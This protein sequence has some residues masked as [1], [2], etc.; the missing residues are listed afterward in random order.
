M[1]NGKG[2]VEKIGEFKSASGA[3]MYNLQISGDRFGFGSNKPPCSEGDTIEFEY[4]QKGQY[5][6]GNSK[7]VVVVAKS[8]AGAS[9]S[10]GG[11]RSYGKDPATQTTIS[12]QSALNSALA[13]VNTLVLADAVPG[14]T[15]TAKAEDKYGILESLVVEKT[16]EYYAQST[17][18]E[19]PEE[20]V[21]SKPV[22]DKVASAKKDWT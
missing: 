17:G 7:S 1:S 22:E 20:E 3:T 21:E 13:F 19:W 6:N 10:V 5:K 14:V 2:V 4:E 8:V 15:K 11:G 18:T 9:G 16:H 12:K